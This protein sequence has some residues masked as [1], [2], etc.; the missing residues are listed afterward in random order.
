MAYTKQNPFNSCAIVATG[1]QILPGMESTAK[2]IF[3]T[4]GS[5]RN[6]FKNNF[7]KYFWRMSKIDLLDRYIGHN[8][9]NR[10]EGGGYQ[11]NNRDGIVA[12]L[13]KH[14]IIKEGNYVQKNY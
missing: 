11:W 6:K 5:S 1:K 13:L 10:T 2:C 7:L 9:R 14:T 3:G 8:I 12:E 4:I